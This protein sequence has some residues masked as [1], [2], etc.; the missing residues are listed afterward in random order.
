M[1]TQW[2]V[3]RILRCDANYEVLDD[4]YQSWLMDAGACVIDPLPAARA[5]ERIAPLD[6]PLLARTIRAH[7]Q[8]RV[9][10]DSSV[11]AWD[12]SGVLRELGSLKTSGI[13]E[14]WR[15]HVSSLRTRTSGAPVSTLRAAS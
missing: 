11:H 6:M 12:V 3:P 1:P 5:G 10:A 14:L 15:T 2:L 9:H 4:F 8:L 7:T 13:I